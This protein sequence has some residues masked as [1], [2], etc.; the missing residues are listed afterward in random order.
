MS[1]QLKIARQFGYRETVFYLRLKREEGV[2][3]TKHEQARWDRHQRKEQRKRRRRGLKLKEFRNRVGLSQEA[4]ANLLSIS[5]RTVCYY[6]D[7]HH[8]P[9]TACCIRLIYIGFS[10]WGC[11]WSLNRSDSLRHIANVEGGYVTARDVLTFYSWWLG[12][13]ADNVRDYVWRSWEQMLDT[14]GGYA[15]DCDR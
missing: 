12:E 15:F 4:L 3:F 8:A 10:Y 6:E 5:R 9:K 1:E 14:G 11:K 7:G 13:H 2:A